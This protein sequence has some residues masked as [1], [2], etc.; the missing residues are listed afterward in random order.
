MILIVLLA[1]EELD[2]GETGVGYLN[3]AVGAGGLAGGV[4][5]LA[6]ARRRLALPFGIGILVWGVPIVL[7]GV[8]A[9]PAAVVLLVVVWG[10]A[11][12]TSPD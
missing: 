1:L 4:I 8:F 6:A 2:L 3:S 5:A 7:V 11:S 12:S 10:T 9:S